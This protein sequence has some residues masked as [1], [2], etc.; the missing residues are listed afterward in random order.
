[1]TMETI[2]KRTSWLAMATA[3]FVVASLTGC[4]GSSTGPTKLTSIAVTPATASVAKDSTQ[5]FTAKGTY[6]DNT[7]KDI[8][9]MVT[10]ASTMT[11]VATVSTTGLATGK[12]AGM[13]A[14]TAT[15]LGVT[16]SAALTVTASTTPITL[17]SIAV[18]PTNPMIGVGTKQ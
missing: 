14:I 1:M 5:Q 6:S 9:S 18:M 13:T 15:M 16:G 10:W 8:S 12:A 4:G 11:T 2:A 7:S 17:V 3:I